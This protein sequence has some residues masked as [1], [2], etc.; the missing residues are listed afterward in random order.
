MFSSVISTLLLFVLCFTTFHPRPVDSNVTYIAPELQNSSCTPTQSP[1][2][3]LSQYRISG[4]PSSNTTF[5]FLPGN[6]HLSYQ[7]SVTNIHHLTFSALNDNVTVTINC[8]SSGNLLLEAIQEVHVNNIDFNGCIMNRM[9]TI[10]HLILIYLRFHKQ[11]SSYYSTLELVNVNAI[12]TNCYFS[13]EID[14]MDY[15]SGA[16]VVTRS[17]A[18]IANSLFVGNRAQSGGAI[19]ATDDSTL[20][21]ENNVFD[22]NRAIRG[23]AIMT[24]VSSS[25]SILNNNFSNNIGLYGGALNIE[26]SEVNVISTIFHNNSAQDDYN[27]WS[28]YGGAMY[29]NNATII[30]DDVT[31]VS[32][33]A[34]LGGGIYAIRYSTVTITGNSVVSHNY[35]DYGGGGIYVSSSSS[36][37]LYDNSRVDNNHAGYCGGGIY[38]ISN[39]TLFIAGNN[40]INSNQAWYGGGG[41]Y[42]TD[43][44]TVTLTGGS[45]VSNN[46]ASYGGALYCG[47]NLIVFINHSTL[48]NNTADYGGGVDGY[49]C[50]L[51]IYNSNFELNTAM[52]DG[53]AINGGI[54]LN[55]YNTGFATNKVVYGRGGAI[56]TYQKF[57]RLIRCILHNN[58]A[59]QCGALTATMLEI[60]QSIFTHNTATGVDERG[61][62]GALCVWNGY[63]NIDT[64]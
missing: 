48:V 59:S 25:I 18:S 52:F 2:Y 55:I 34:R 63:V 13:A 7:L 21:L 43:H 6:H 31:L 8:T 29:C 10:S 27:S 16:L 5:M 30:I 60:N 17:N 42:V 51:E 56:N 37:S 38:A 57:L 24:S 3:T 4:V 11:G 44:S 46:Q 45:T 15:S 62:G 53:G 9:L 12:I 23:G 36:F 14:D 20:S 40:T 58:T 32:N 33:R 41:I 50:I 35:A 54:E 47:W 39:C 61:G 22:S 28:Q 49:E 1:C 26:Q 64:K 19:H